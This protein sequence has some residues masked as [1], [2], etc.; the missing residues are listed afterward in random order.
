MVNSPSPPRL[1]FRE[2][3]QGKVQEWNHQGLTRENKMQQAPVL[4][5]VRKANAPL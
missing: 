4:C 2:L 1:M 3:R 5:E